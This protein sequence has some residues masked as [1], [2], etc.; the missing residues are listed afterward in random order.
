MKLFIL[1]IVFLALFQTSFAQKYEYNV[2]GEHFSDTLYTNKVT[3]TTNPVITEE[4]KAIFE[5]PKDTAYIYH[6]IGEG[7]N[8]E[9]I[10]NLYQ[11]CAPCLAKWNKLDYSDFSSFRKQ[12]LYT[13]EYLKVAIKKSYEK[14]IPEKFEIRK[15]Y[16]NIK[17]R[18]YIYDIVRNYNVNISDLRLWN[19]LSENVYY[20]EDT[21]LIVGEIEYK[22]TCPC[23]E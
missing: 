16:Q 13:G 21:R 6:Q 11:I 5:R 8:I 12:S 22:Y 9:Y 7:E 18:T 19:G 1:S 3:T 23:L 2:V 10:L 17:K 15:H 14:G 20:V 4:R